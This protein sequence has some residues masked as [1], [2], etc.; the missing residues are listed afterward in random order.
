M[1]NTRILNKSILN[2]DIDMVKSLLINE[3]S[4]SPD[5]NKSAIDLTSRLGYVDILKIFLNDERFKKIKDSCAI[6]ESARNGYVE[7]VKLLLKDKRFSLLSHTYWTIEGAVERGHLSVVKVLL[8]YGLF[9]PSNS[10][11]HF[12]IQAAANNNL[13]M[14]QLLWKD[15]R[16]KDSLL[17]DQPD[18]YNKFKTL[19]IQK[20]IETF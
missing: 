5:I 12:I 7:V 1:I 10:S 18:L 11:N 14:V 6:V 8:K 2:N 3:V 20:N 9:N 17:K 19:D 13:E 4:N 15:E 16:V